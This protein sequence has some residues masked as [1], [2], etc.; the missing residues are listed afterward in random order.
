MA[1]Y[2]FRGI[3]PRV[4]HA[5]RLAW[6]VF[7]L[8]TCTFLTGAFV[9]EALSDHN[10]ARNHKSS[11]EFAWFVS[12]GCLFAGQCV[13]LQRYVQN[14]WKTCRNTEVSVY[15]PRIQRYVWP[16]TNCLV[17]VLLF[18]VLVAVADSKQALRELES[19]EFA[20][21]TLFVLVACVCF[22]CATRKKYSSEH[23]GRRP[24]VQ[25]S[26]TESGALQFV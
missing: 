22:M 18:A 3:D 20:L 19:P 23:V 9:V 14:T 15:P 4:A 2:R 11:A 13:A 12:S 1:P 24:A 5:F 25:F 26:M 16:R 21:Y 17:H 6:C 10:A 8:N 7:V